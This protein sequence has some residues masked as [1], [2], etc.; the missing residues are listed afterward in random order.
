M[1]QRLREDDLVLLASG[2]R[3]TPAKLRLL[4]KDPKWSFRQAIRK[5][6]VM[7]PLTPRSTAASLLRFLSNRDLKAIHDG[8]NT[9]IY[10]R[11]CIESLQKARC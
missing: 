10:V 3:V 8:P 11:K 6:V 7:N 4:G 9:S 1:N 2:E 5:A